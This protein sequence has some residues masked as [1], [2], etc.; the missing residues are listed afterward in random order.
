MIKT[1]KKIRKVE[2]RAFKIGILFEVIEYCV[3]TAEA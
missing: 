3:I 2:K 1:P